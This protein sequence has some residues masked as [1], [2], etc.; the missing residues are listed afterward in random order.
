M[1]AAR[2]SGRPS[3]V[4]GEVVLDGDVF[5]VVEEFPLGL[6]TTMSPVK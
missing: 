4:G 3:G 1:V 2:D 5:E 6:V